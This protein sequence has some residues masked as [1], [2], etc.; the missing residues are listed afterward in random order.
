MM[1]KRDNKLELFLESN[2]GHEFI[3]LLV[4]I[5]A[6]IWG[7][8]T[9]SWSHKPGISH[10]LNLIDQTLLG[11]FLVE[12][13]VRIYASGFRFFEKGWNLFDTFV[14]LIAL[15]PA[16]GALSTLRTLRILRVMRLVE[17]FPKMRLVVSSVCRAVPGILSVA[18]IL[19]LSFY[20]AS[21][22][23]FNLF[24]NDSE[25]FRSLPRSM[26]T[27]FQLM[28]GDDWGS[29]VESLLQNHPYCYLFFIPFMILMTFTV[30]N[31]FFGLV[32]NS[33]QEAAEAENKSMETISEEESSLRDDIKDLKDQLEEIKRLVTR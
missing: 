20:V 4:V 9:F 6:L 17:L 25:H 26:F 10:V 7:L 30:L 21:I 23:A 13:V 19:L 32:V 33:M 3:G 18:G 1:L 8:Q 14:I 15:V 5:N 11:V 2:Q 16:A 29:I 12:L 27:L 28:L 22:I 31:L 24:G